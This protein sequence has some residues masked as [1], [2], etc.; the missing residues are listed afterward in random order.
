ME[1]KKWGEMVASVNLFASA[2][3]SI[4]PKIQLFNAQVRLNY[5]FNVI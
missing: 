2:F 3:N 1:G 4:V 5:I